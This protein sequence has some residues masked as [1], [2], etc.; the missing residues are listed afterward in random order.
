MYEYGTLQPVEVI[1][2]RGRGKRENNVGDEPNWGTLCAYGN[3]TMKLPIQLF[4]PNKDIFKKKY[5]ELSQA[6][7]LVSLKQEGEAGRAWD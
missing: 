6:L 2:Q 1:L 4:C 3:V 5:N 7:G